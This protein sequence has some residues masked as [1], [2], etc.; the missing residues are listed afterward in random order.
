VCDGDVGAFAS[1]FRKIVASVA[2]EVTVQEAVAVSDVMETQG[3]L[4]RWVFGMQVVLAGIAFLLSI[5][6]LYA[7]MSFTVS[8]RTHEIGIRTALDAHVWGIVS[9]I[10]R[11]AVIQLSVGLALGAVWA[12]ILLREIANDAIVIPI[13]LPATISVTTVVAALVGVIACASPM[14]RGLRIQPTEALREF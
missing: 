14:L 8:Q 12:W 2:P 7:L 4:Y 6:G 9:T 13:N 3:G 11:R 5:T 10:A 1:R